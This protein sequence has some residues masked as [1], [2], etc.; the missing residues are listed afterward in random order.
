M[1]SAALTVIHHQSESQRRQGLHVEVGNRLPDPYDTQ[2]L[3]EKQ[4]NRL[5][6]ALGPITNI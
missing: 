5:S 2:N 4:R 3:G 6:G 1:G